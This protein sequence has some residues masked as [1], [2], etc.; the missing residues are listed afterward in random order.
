[1]RYFNRAELITAWRSLQELCPKISNELDFW[2]FL[3]ISPTIAWVGSGEHMGEYSMSD[4]CGAKVDLLL[5][6][7]RETLFKAWVI[8]NPDFNWSW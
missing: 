8:N 1:M 7:H 2:K 3:G 4:T 5:S 6:P